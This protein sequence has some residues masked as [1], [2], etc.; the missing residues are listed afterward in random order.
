MFQF[1]KGRLIIVRILLLSA[2]IILI[3]VGIAT[4]YAVYHPAEGS[5]RVFLSEERS[6]GSQ[7]DLPPRLASG[8]AEA[9]KTSNRWKKQLFFAILG[10]AAFI[11]VNKANYRRL[12]EI[13]YGL[14]GFVLILLAM[15]LVDK[16][17]VNIPDIL[18]ER[19]RETYA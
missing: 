4:I 12:G 1:L 18:I 9:G 3:G 8:D 6:G 2:T 11:L 13:S 10:F 15:L 16:Y 7:T 19:N 14:Y 5:P 17:I